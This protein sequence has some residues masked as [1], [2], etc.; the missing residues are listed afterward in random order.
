MAVI[1]LYLALL[2]IDTGLGMAISG[3][4]ASIYGL[5]QRMVLESMIS[6]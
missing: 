6:S 1:H 3:L 5:E 2:V 4:A